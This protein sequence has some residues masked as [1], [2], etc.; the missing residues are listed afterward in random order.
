[1]GST[2]NICG[3]PF[4]IKE[5]NEIP[6]DIKGEIIHGE[7]HHSKSE[8]LIRDSLPNELKQLALIHEWIHGVLVMIGR[9]DL[10]DDE[11][12]VQNV[13]LAIN[14]AFEVKQI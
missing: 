14:Q 13:A 8:I 12:L 5:I 7:I 11:V 6:A 2:I 1:M 4:E 9:A 3:I 10:S